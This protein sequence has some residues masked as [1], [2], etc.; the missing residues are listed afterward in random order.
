VDAGLGVTAR[1]R[2]FSERLVGAA[3]AAALPALPQVTYVRHTRANPHP[4]IC[5]LADLM[6]AAVLDLEPESAA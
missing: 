3:A 1:T 2:I 6:N 5:R 4:T